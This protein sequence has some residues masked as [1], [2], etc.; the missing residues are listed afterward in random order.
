MKKLLSLIL[1]FIIITLTL[2]VN[3]QSITELEISELE[4]SS[5]ELILKQL[6][7]K[8]GDTYS[9]EQLKLS[10]RILL[11]SDL[12]NPLTLRVSSNKIENNNYQILIDAE[13][14][15][16][17]MIHPWEFGIRKATGILGEKFEQKIRN[18]HG[19]GLSY[20]FAVD[21]SNDSYAQY[22]LEY[23]GT[24][25]RIYSFNYRNFDSDLEFNQ[26]EFES[27]GAFYQLNL[28]SLPS[29]EIKN[30]YSIRFQEN[31]YQINNVN[32]KQEYLI[33][34]YTFNYGN[35]FEFELELSRAFSLNDNF[36]DF[37]SL[38]FN[39]N[40]E[41]RVN[42]DTKIIADLKGGLSSDDTPLNYQFRAGSFSKNDGGI[43]IRGQDYEF[44]GTKYFKNTLEFQKKLWRRDLWGVVFIDSAKI[45]EADQELGA[46]DWENDAGLGLIYYTFLGPIRADIA[47]DNL[48]SSPRFNIGFGSSF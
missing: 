40:K 43:P 6:P 10:R 42:E 17:F 31:D 3:A 34:A 16:I 23:V 25:G 45:A 7:Y 26:Q 29:A 24:E 1:F 41:Y 46:L 5:K 32:Q 8:N 22:G 2:S 12:L 48:D 15:G 39:F 14:S 38:K 37:N 28:E 4:R 9:E 44:A 18:P 36:N 13:E 11:N 35:D 30:I 19:N 47:F 21:W 27:D 33:P 20:L